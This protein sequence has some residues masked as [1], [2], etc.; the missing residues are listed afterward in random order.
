MYTIKRMP[1]FDE[2]LNG[3]RDGMTRI[4]LA[5]RLDG[6]GGDEAADGGGQLWT[7]PD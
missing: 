4:R 3:I 1:E 6:G 2:W 5:R 7:L